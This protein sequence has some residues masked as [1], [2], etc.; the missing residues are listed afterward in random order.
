MLHDLGRALFEA[1][2]F[3]FAINHPFGGALV[4]SEYYNRT[5]AVYA[6]MVALN[7]QLYMDEQSG[8]RLVTFKEVVTKIRGGAAAVDPRITAAY[9]ELTHMASQKLAV[10]EEQ[11]HT[12]THRVGSLNLG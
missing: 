1:S 11:I 6:I 3:N 10:P 9:G 2:R 4:P 8:Q 12:A 7:R 5:P